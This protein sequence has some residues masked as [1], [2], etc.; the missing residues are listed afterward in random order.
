[1]HAT[2]PDGNGRSERFYTT[3]SEIIEGLPRY[4]RSNP[5]Q[6]YYKMRIT[7]PHSRT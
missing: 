7:Y 2:P 5:P 6:G 4:S 1:M 3:R